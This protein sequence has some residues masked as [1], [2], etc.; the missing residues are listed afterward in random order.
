MED[1][2]R[3]TLCHGSQNR[4]VLIDGVAQADLLRRIAPEQLAREV[5]YDG[6]LLLVKEEAGYTMRMYNS[7]GTAAEMCGNGMRCV[8]R[9]ARERYLEQEYFTLYSGGRPYP[10]SCE[11]PI[12]EGIPTFGVEIAI[13]LSG[14]D[15]PKGG[16]RYLAEEIPQLHP[17]LRFSYL[18]LGNPHIVAE[19]E[20]VDFNLLQG[21]GERVKELREWFPRGINL[22]LFRYDGPQQ[23]FVATYERGVGITESC[24]TAM[25]ASA[26]AATLLG[27]T[28]E[29]LPIEVFNRGGAV[30]CICTQEEGVL[31][32]R[33]VGNATFESYGTIRH[34]AGRYT[35]QQEGEYAAEQ[36]A[37]NNFL[38]RL[39]GKER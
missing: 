25:T 34:K 18:N 33:L 14:S 6:L 3:Y 24:G 10:I 35:L 19:V 1:F 11:E 28:R 30:R 23:L 36:I 13:R 32:T 2:L 9:L 27:L 5:G 26:T 38:E 20:E 39:K 4:F 37:Y 16:E 12:L 8:A 17:S 29:G 21:L 31:M 7:D 15:F 22:S